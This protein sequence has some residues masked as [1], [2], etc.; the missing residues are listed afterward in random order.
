MISGG[1]FGNFGS[2]SGN[3]L[4]ASIGTLG[5]W[6]GSLP[7]IPVAGIQSAIRANVSQVIGSDPNFQIAL[8]PSPLIRFPDFDSYWVSPAN[9]SIELSPELET[10]LARDPIPDHS[11]IRALDHLLGKVFG[12]NSLL[13]WAHNLKPAVSAAD[14][15]RSIVADVQGISP[16][17]WLQIPR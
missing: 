9:T 13:D 6:H 5:V 10:L 1:A 11:P 17:L 15:G 4:I 3:T 16:G 8:D 12:H 7:S 14:P 2:R